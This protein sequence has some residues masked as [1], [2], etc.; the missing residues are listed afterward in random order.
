[1]KLLYV[2]VLSERQKGRIV[3]LAVKLNQ[4]MEKPVQ[5]ITPT[6]S[7]VNSLKDWRAMWYEALDTAAEF[8]NF[9][10]AKTLDAKFTSADSIG[11][12]R[13]NERNLVFTA[14]CTFPALCR[15]SFSYR[16]HESPMVFY[17][18]LNVSKEVI[19]RI[20]IEGVTPRDT[21][22][23]KFNLWDALKGADVEHH[24][25]DEHGIT[26]TTAITCELLEDGTVSCTN[27]TGGVDFVVALCDTNCL[28]MKV[29]Q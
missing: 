29:I 11:L 25:I 14:P 5:K 7:V 28:F 24:S 27:E 18:E 21:Y 13:D 20:A 26:T 4:D 15:L 8:S 17:T 16:Q 1:M 22:L 23:R 3:L 12:K 10:P 19:K 6:I 9:N 2:P